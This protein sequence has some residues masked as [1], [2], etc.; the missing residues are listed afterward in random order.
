MLHG[1]GS[2]AAVWDPVRTILGEHFDCVVPELPGHGTSQYAETGLI[3]LAEQLL[4]AASRPAIWLGWSLGALIAMQAA[5]L[6]RSGQ[7]LR[8]LL[9]AGT[10]AF[11]RSQQWLSAMPANTFD[12]YLQTYIQNAMLAQKRF[13]ALQAKGDQHALQVRQALSQTASMPGEQLLWGLN[14]L[15]SAD[16]TDRFSRIN[17]PVHCLYGEHDALVPVT[18]ANVMRSRF[19]AQ[20][21]V[22]PDTGHAPFLS[23]AARFA[24][25]V[26]EVS[27]A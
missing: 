18:L 20:V 6:A 23:D 13:I 4:A 2:S 14:L 10:P 5:L 12:E 11:V 1:W 8:L 15:R 19:N 9:V 17:S 24:A 25:W 21:T 3:P 16:L 27:D 22:W 7:V 26:R